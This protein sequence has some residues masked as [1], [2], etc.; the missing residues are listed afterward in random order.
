MVRNTFEA[1][2]GNPPNGPAVAQF[3][4]NGQPESQENG[5]TASPTDEDVARLAYSFWE[6]RGC[7]EGSPDED[8]F[9]AEQE[10]S[11]RL[12]SPAK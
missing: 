1:R 2:P 4:S 11:R 12:S 8:W 3:E 7:R 6:E 9:R 10:L 5:R